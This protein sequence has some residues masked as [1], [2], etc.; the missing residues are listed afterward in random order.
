LAAVLCLC[1][2]AASATA[3]AGEAGQTGEPGL[4]GEDA[5]MAAA[6]LAALHDDADWELLRRDA[7]S[8]VDIY[9]KDVDGMSLPA[10]RAEKVV[11]ANSD[12]LFELIV[13]LNRHAGLSETIP[14]SHST[15]LSR[16]G[17]QLDYMQYL[18]SPAWT[19]ARDRYWFNRARVQRNLA[20]QLGHHRLSWHGID[21]ARYPRQRRALL[22]GHEDAIRTPINY[23]SWEAIALAGG[24]SRLVYRVLSDPGGSLPRAA[25]LLVT[26]RTL[27]ENLLQFEAELLRSSAQAVD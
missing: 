2:V 15:V 16:R 12:R 24:R 22:A 20:G 13:D 21:P 26:S 27:P 23:G 25:Q 4:A 9:R 8:G 18:D 1:A 10:F 14:L 17:D 5:A 11:A 3:W 7:R 6:V 19:L